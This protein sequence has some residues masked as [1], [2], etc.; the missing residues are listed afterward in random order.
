MG[1]FNEACDAQNNLTMQSVLDAEFLLD[2]HEEKGLTTSIVVD[3]NAASTQHVVLKSENMAMG[4]G[5][6]LL[7]GEGYTGS[8]TLECL[9][10]VRAQVDSFSKHEPCRIFAGGGVNPPGKAHPSRHFSRS[11]AFP[12]CQELL[13]SREEKAAAE[14]RIA[15]PFMPLCGSIVLHDPRKE[16]LKDTH[17][18]LDPRGDLAVA[19]NLDEN[20]AG[21]AKK[22]A[23]WKGYNY[24][25]IMRYGDD[26]SAKLG[27]LEASTLYE[28]SLLRQEA[29][30][31]HLK[32]QGYSHDDDET[33]VSSVRADMSIDA[34]RYKNAKLLKLDKDRQDL[35]IK[36]QAANV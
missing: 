9:R 14:R 30:E 31:K 6:D 36:F 22:Y 27:F 1:N 12:L 24:N 16:N 20:L 15:L 8:Y 17:L 11:R 26:E 3:T 4:G 5:S 35:K 29:L 13:L 32:R 10:L 19:M 34:I 21:P 25:Q 23:T 18:K 33:I 7:I 2:T 28:P